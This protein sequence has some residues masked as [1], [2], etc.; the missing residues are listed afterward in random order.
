MVAS[1]SLQGSRLTSPYATNVRTACSS[2]IK[3]VYVVVAV[4]TGRTRLFLHGGDSLIIFRPNTHILPIFCF[5][6]PLFM[7]FIPFI[8]PFPSYFCLKSSI[9]PTHY[10]LYTIHYALL[11]AVAATNF[12][13]STVHITSSYH[14]VCSV[15]RC[16]ARWA[17]GGTLA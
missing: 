16:M 4:K 11:G 12:T 14:G 7:S 6:P 13:A 8:P 3:V 10:T 5:I 17:T 9:F 1:S 15:G 2:S